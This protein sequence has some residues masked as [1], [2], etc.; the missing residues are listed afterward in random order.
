MCMDS[1]NRKICFPCIK[2][3]GKICSRFESDFSF[4]FYTGKNKFS[5][6]WNPCT[7]KCVTY[8][9]SKLSDCLQIFFKMLFRFSSYPEKCSKRPRS[10]ANNIFKIITIFWQ[11][12]SARG[13]STYMEK[14][15]QYLTL[16]RNIHFHHGKPKPKVAVP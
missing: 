9:F 8:E 3:T 1:K 7:S 10:A 16:F 4:V 2:Y 6:F 15:S 14:E 12:M 13:E 11:R 5:D